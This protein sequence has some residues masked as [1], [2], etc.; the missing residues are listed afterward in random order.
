[1]SSSSTP[2][3]AAPPDSHHTNIPPLLHSATGGYRERLSEE[4]TPMAMQ[5]LVDLCGDDDAKWLACERTVNQAMR[6][7]VALWDGTVQAIR[8]VRAHA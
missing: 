8:A 7:R 6:A 4:H 5:M 2:N 3:T 1:P